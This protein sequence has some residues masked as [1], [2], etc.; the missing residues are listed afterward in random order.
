MS[1]GGPGFFEQLT[2]HFSDGAAVDAFDAA[3]QTF[4]SVQDNLQRILNSRRGAL[5]HL[6]DYGLED[7]SEIYRH[8]PASAHKLRQAMEATLL[9]YEPRLKAVEVVIEAPEPGVLLSFTMRCELHRTGL[10][11]FGT[12][13]LPDGQV[14]LAL[15]MAGWDR[16]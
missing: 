11:R 15:Q 16:D 8:L 9:K 13:F 3:T 7:L 12:H 4:L 10:V 5:A 2:G 14:R 6:P 1:H